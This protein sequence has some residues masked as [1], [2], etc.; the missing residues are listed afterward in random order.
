VGCRVRVEF[1]GFV[2]PAGY[3][4]P[5]S[6]E[7]DPHLRSLARRRAQGG[8]ERGDRPGA[9]RSQ[10]ADPEGGSAPAERRGLS[11]A[12][13][14]RCRWQL[15]GAAT[16]AAGGSRVWLPLSASRSPFPPLSPTLD[17]GES[18]AKSRYA[19]TWKQRYLSLPLG[20]FF[21]F[22]PREEVLPGGW[23]QAPGGSR[24]EGS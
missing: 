12:P 7:G 14:A 17:P 4:A 11:Q 22:P 23:E 19:E 6:M 13:N 9:G 20:Y 2:E 10:R 5:E 8:A 21:F 15:G 24:E 1:S 16:T 3:K 18:E